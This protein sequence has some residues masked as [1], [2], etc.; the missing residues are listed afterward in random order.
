V[1]PAAARGEV[2]AVLDTPTGQTI[3]GWVV[4]RPP[5]RPVRWVLAFSRNR[6]VAVGWTPY[7]R[8][9]IAERYGPGALASG[10]QLRPPPEYGTP[11]PDTLRVF[12]VTGGRATEL[13]RSGE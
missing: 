10:F 8:P 9:E 12:S 13:R 4:A 6:L 11:D 5:S 1:D 3:A 7:L 2:E